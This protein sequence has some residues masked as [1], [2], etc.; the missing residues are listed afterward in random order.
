MNTNP[1]RDEKVD[2]VLFYS[3]K[4]K[5]ALS[6]SHSTNRALPAISLNSAPGS[7]DLKRVAVMMMMY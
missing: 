4:T 5:G 2:A 6:T 3:E 7:L 1:K